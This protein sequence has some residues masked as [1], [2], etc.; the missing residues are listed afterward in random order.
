MLILGVDIGNTHTEVGIINEDEV[1]DSIRI[2][3]ILQK[4]EDEFWFY[5]D[6][7]L[8]RNQMSPVLFEHIVVS[9]VV[10]GLN[11]VFQR[12][13]EKYFKK[14]VTFIRGDL[15]LEL[16]IHY[17]NPIHVGADRICNAVAAWKIYHTNC[18]VLDFGT[19]TTFDIVF[20]EGTYE[21]GIIA[22]GLETTNWGLHARADLL[23]RVSL[24]YPEVVI[25]KDTETAI[26][27]G[28]MKGTVKLIDGLI[29][30]IIRETGRQF[31][32]LATGGLARLIIPH[33][34]HPVIIEPNLVLL[35]I[36]FIAETLLKYG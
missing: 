14:P 5:I 28:L 9:S 15:P 24:I 23:P 3:S 22:A 6:H 12:L 21:G 4:T 8:S 26:Q 30:E 34:K 31:Q 32:I 16:K 20:E 1:V 2:S 10:P 35:G 17:K 7:F 33:L 36:K 18:I 27:I 19:A 11:F 25:G 29:D 13:F